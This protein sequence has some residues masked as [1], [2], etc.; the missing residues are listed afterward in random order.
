MNQNNN[1]SYTEHM[2]SIIDHLIELKTG[3]QGPVGPVETGAE[4][5]SYNS[6]DRDLKQGITHHVAVCLLFQPNLSDVSNDTVIH[7]FN[8][9]NKTKG[10]LALQ[11]TEFV[12]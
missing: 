9:K 8:D 2:Q 5:Q 1:C 12:S 4:T 6:I 11:D 10:Y 3:D 7:D